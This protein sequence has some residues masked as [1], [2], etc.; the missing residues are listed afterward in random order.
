MKNMI[1]NLIIKALKDNAYPSEMESEISNKRFITFQ[2]IG[3]LIAAI[4]GI[5]TIIQVVID[6][7]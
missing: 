5:F 4:G 3:I 7:T 2:I 1:E 6:N